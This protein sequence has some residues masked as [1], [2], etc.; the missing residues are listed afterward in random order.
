MDLTRSLSQR[1][2]S[3][4]YDVLVTCDLSMIEPADD[5]KVYNEQVVYVGSPSHVHGKNLS[6]VRSMPIPNI[7]C[8]RDILTTWLRGHEHD[9]CSHQV[10]RA[11]RSQLPCSAG[12][13]DGKMPA[14]GTRNWP[15]RFGALRRSG[16]GTGI[17]M[18]IG[19]M[20]SIA[21]TILKSLGLFAGGSSAFAKGRAP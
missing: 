3:D 19:P 8:R 17:G 5:W 7:T 13:H 2:S 4:D 9:L 1:T 16:R 18:H 21:V 20:R 14:D 10:G 11:T 15:Q 12:G 6:I